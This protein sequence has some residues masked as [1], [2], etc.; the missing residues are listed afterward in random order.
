MTVS[1]TYA[2]G[3]VSYRLSYYRA[4]YY[5]PITGRFL[6]EDPMG[7]AGGG[8]NLYAYVGGDPTDFDDPSGEGYASGLP[9]LTIR[10]VVYLG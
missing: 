8:P 9:L 7:F 5:N 1:T 6:S 4:R 3:G 10:R 2:I